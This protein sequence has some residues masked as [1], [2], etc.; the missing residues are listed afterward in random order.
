M[1]HFNVGWNAKASAD[2][3][4]LDPWTVE[5]CAQEC[6]RKS[7]GYW[8]RLFAGAIR[9]LLSSTRPPSTD[10]LRD[11][12]AE[13]QRQ[14]EREGWTPEHDDQHN[15]GEL[16]EAAICYLQG[17]ERWGYGNPHQRWPWER[18][19]WKPKDRRSNL[20]RA[21]ALILAEIERFDRAALTRA[22]EVQRG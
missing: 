5:A 4:T 3:P 22:K 7:S 20:V 16:S 13:R 10:A 19:Y 15:G 9:D 11:V 6:E 2:A 1:T 17:D 21:G 14:I 12:A 8:S 18:A